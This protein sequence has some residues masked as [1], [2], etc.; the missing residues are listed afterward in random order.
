MTRVSHEIG[1]FVIIHQILLFELVM[2]QDPQIVMKN[3]GEHAKG[4]RYPETALRAPQEV[5][6]AAGDDRVRVLTPVHEVQLL[7]S[8]FY[9]L[10]S[11]RNSVDGHTFSLVTEIFLSEIS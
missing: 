9:H 10:L 4:R 2:H 1:E 6:L 7:E 3:E 11:H 5:L 8:L